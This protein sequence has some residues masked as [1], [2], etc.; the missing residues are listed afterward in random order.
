MRAK[1][2]SKRS[3]SHRMECCGVAHSYVM[4]SFLSLDKTEGWGGE[5]TGEVFVVVWQPAVSREKNNDNKRRRRTD[6]HCVTARQDYTKRPTKTPERVGG[7]GREREGKQKAENKQ[8]NSSGKGK[9]SG[10]ETVGQT[11]T[12]S[13]GRLF[14]LLLYAASVSYFSMISW[15]GH[16]RTIPS[17]APDA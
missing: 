7:R 9:R 16:T 1:Q 8:R 15:D 11:L 2:A 10:R 4:V 12:L 3:S 17:S 5:E 14:L 6:G 13:W